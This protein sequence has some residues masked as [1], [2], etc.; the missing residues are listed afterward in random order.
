[1]LKLLKYFMVEKVFFVTTHGQ[2]NIVKLFPDRLNLLLIS[3]CQV[4][5]IAVIVVDC[6]LQVI[7][8]W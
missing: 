8:V 1:M 2:F 6:S 5:V 7:V 4:A 3:N